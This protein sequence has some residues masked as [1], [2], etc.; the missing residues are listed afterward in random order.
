MTSII[1]MTC[2]H[3]SADYEAEDFCFAFNKPCHNVAECSAFSWKPFPEVWQHRETRNVLVQ[4]HR[5]NVTTVEGVLAIYKRFGSDEWLGMPVG[6]FEIQ[7]RLVERN[8]ETMNGD[9]NEN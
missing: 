6:Q 5:N 2:A 7:F 9:N 3:K 4:R 8:G 1:C